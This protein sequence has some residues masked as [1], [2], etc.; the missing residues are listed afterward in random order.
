MI[1][2]RFA[3][4]LLAAGLLLGGCAAQGP[5]GGG[6]QTAAAG[7]FC[8]ETA[9]LVSQAQRFNF[10]TEF[11]NAEAIWT[12]LSSLYADPDR[13]PRQI[14][15]DDLPRYSE[16]MAN[17]A[18]VYSNQRKFIAAEGMFLAAERQANL[19]AQEAEAAAEAGFVKVLRTQH[20]LNRATAGDSDALD[21]IAGLVDDQ[22]AAVEATP[23]AADVAQVLQLSLK[24]QRARLIASLGEFSRSFV[25][26][27]QEDY[28]RAE[29]AIDRALVLIAPVPGA[30]TNYAPR[31]ATTKA[32]LQIGQ[33]KHEAARDT[34][35]WAAAAYSEDLADTAL[36]ARALAFQARAETLLGERDAALD[37]YARAFDIYQ[38]TAVPIGYDLVWPYFNLALTT[39]QAQPERTET[40]TRAI[41]AAAQTLRSRAV[42]A[43]LAVAAQDKAEGSGPEA[44]AIR[45][46]VAA[47][48]EFQRIEADRNTVESSPFASETQKSDVRRRYREAAEVLETRRAAL[49]ESAGDYVGLLSAKTDVDAV[50][51]A[52]RADEALVQIVPGEPYS[53]AFVVTPDGIRA[54]RIGGTRDEGKMSRDLMRL[55]VE[56]LRDD[57]QRGLPYEPNLS[58]AL[59]REMVAPSLELLGGFKPKRLIFALSDALTTLPMEAL[60]VKPTPLDD[61]L[62]RKDFSDVEWLGDEYQ[63]AYV[64]APSTLVALRGGA[65]EE[66]GAADRS[67]LTLSAW[68]DFQPGATAADIL[69]D[70]LPDECAPEAQAV[71]RL[72]ALAGSPPELEILSNIFGARAEIRAGAEF[73]E[74]AV[75]AASDSGALGRAD[76]VHFSTHGFLPR[77]DDCLNQGALTVSVDGP[78]QDGLLDESDIRRL[79]LSGA[80]LV[81][82]TACDTAGP[83]DARQEGNVSEGGEALSGLARAFF[84]AGARAALVTHWQIVDGDPLLRLVETFYTE[85]ET[86][87]SYTAALR[88][89]QKTVRSE[90]AYSDPRYW[91]AFVLV[92][93]GGA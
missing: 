43:S 22:A 27:Q 1:R 47:Q 15:G 10:L 62:R 75:F 20:A 2:L 36:R 7:S 93:D 50:M 59:Y 44:E 18:L 79:D 21:T 71:A 13:N 24:A 63:I 54:A 70:Y 78:G 58:N 23:I 42:A 85:L 17:Q 4:P 82:L 86:G 14:C 68:G 40:L 64:P 34:A 6:T 53:M 61:T 5:D 3:A 26:L 52:L 46:F 74:G 28:A 67:A 25:F 41:F 33:G 73:T 16:V 9:S 65:A 29:A 57:L 12:R 92:G 8:E 31:Y 39:M 38:N 83:A 60:A 11:A 89:A 45:A 30:Q 32:L 76:I 87:V 88:R 81:V 91:A 55:V 37:T 80:D 90:T 19:E 35:R 48:R 72:P 69:P 84:D 66:E 49:E 77:S 56:R 51:G